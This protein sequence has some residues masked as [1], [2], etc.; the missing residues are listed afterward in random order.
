MTTV[1]FRICVIGSVTD[2]ADDPKARVAEGERRSGAVSTKEAVGPKE[3]ESESRLRKW[4]TSGV[5]FVATI[6]PQNYLI[7]RT[8]ICKRPRRNADRLPTRDPFVRG[9]GGTA[10]NH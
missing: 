6:Q 1:T 8:L 2:V 4:S 7:G 9:I 3:T 10:L 5:P